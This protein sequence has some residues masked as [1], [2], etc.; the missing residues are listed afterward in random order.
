MAAVL[1]NEQQKQC[2]KCLEPKARTS[3]Y[4]HGEGKE[5]LSAICK[6]CANRRTYEYRKR[7]GASERIENRYSLARCLA[8]NRK[9]PFS[10]S[11]EEYRFLMGKPCFYC[12]GYFGRVKVC[13]GLDR[14]DNSKGYELMNVLPCCGVC[15]RLRHVQFSV[16]ET[17]LM[18]Q[19][20]IQLREAGDRRN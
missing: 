15:N 2:T 3:F 14:I 1:N 7:T 19:Q 13:I 4:R 12:D 17:R 10:L 20:T 9:K 11:L 6:T 18:A 8:R 5:G 16:E